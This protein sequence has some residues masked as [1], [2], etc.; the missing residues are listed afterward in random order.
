MYGSHKFYVSVSFNMTR[1]DAAERGNIV[2][3]VVD[4]V[5]KSDFFSSKEGLLRQFRG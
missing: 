4:F 5:K 1:E 3:Y 2:V